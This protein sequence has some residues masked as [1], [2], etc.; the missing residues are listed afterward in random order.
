MEVG[1]RSG[2]HGSAPASVGRGSQ[3]REDA[4]VPNVEEIARTVVQLRAIL[5]AVDA[6]EL[7]AT[8]V[9]RAHLVGSIEALQRVVDSFA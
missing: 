3:P 4:F 1:A 7:V 8:D 6:G 2:P 5:A 9:E